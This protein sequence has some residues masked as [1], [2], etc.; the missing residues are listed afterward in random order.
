MTIL[1][2]T[3]LV[4]GHL[5]RSLFVDSG[6]L[7]KS[8]HDDLLSVSLM[9]FNAMELEVDF[10]CSDVMIR[11]KVRICSVSD[12]SKHISLLAKQDCSN[13]KHDFLVAKLLY[14]SKCPCVCPYVN[15]VLGET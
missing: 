11:D 13:R 9:S 15:H 8:Q 6:S 4:K 5:R 14:K 10:D 12:L 3:P 1:C 7:D 2:S